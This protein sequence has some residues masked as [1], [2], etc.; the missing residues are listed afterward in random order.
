[1]FSGKASPVVVISGKT[2]ERVFDTPKKS[3]PRKKKKQALRKAQEIL[4]K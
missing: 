4:T 1:M 3:I 2:A